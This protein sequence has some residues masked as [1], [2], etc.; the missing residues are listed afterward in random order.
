MFSSGVFTMTDEELEA[1]AWEVFNKIPIL[2]GKYE[3]V[4][5]TGKT[6]TTSSTETKVHNVRVTFRLVLD[7]LRVTGSDRC[8]MWFNDSG[9]IELS[10]YRYSYTKIGMID[11]IPLEEAQE[12]INDPDSFSVSD[13]WGLTGFTKQLDVEKVRVVMINQHSSG[14]VILQ[15]AYLFSGSAILRWDDKPARFTS[16]VIAVPEK[17]T[18]EAE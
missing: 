4:G 12:R 6:W 16:T 10:I 11:L 9:L 17:Y 8:D 3:Y 14:R 2:D 15:P 1:H 13:E 7:G 5:R 18:Y